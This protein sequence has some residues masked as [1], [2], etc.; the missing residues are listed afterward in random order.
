MAVRDQGTIRSLVWRLPAPTLDP[1]STALVVIDLQLLDADPDGAHGVRAREVVVPAVAALA[2][3]LHAAGGTVAWVRCHA[4][5]PDASDTDARFSPS[6]TR[7]SSRGAALVQVGVGIPCGSITFSAP[8]PV[9]S[10]LCRHGTSKYERTRGSRDGPEGPA[11]GG[12]RE[13]HFS[14]LP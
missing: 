8:P 6:L 4:N 14:R 10:Y 3:D 1:A 9:R 2:E 7:A 13:C 12:A 5:E 11:E